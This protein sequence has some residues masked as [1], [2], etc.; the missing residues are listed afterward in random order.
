MANVTCT[1]SI[2]CVAMRVGRLAASGAP[3]AG[4]TN[5]YVTES[6]IELGMAVQVDEGQERQVK[7]G[8]GDI[9]QILREP[10]KVKGLNLTMQLC[11][12]DAE[13][14]EMLTGATLITETTT[15]IGHM[16][17]AVGG[18]ANP[19]GVA[20]ESWSWGWDGGARAGNAIADPVFLHWVFPL[21]RFTL[22]TI[23]QNED[24]MSIP[25][26]GKCE[27]NPSIATG[28]N[29]DLP[30]ALAAGRLYA[31]YEEDTVPSGSCGYIVQP[32]H[33]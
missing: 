16:A 33:P 24:F 15:T 19:N 21:T 10:D 14:L 5:M 29:N 25:L 31:V 8:A 30:A 6:I 32:A 27:E 13:L 23:T 2:K 26:S 9:C 4:A 28:P 20:L 22:G 12:L 7:N 17:P 3:A 18:Q 1:G 11:E